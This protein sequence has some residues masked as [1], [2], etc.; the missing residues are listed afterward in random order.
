[1]GQ[2]LKP[3]RQLWAYVQSIPEPDRAIIGLGKRDSAFN[4]G[5]PEPAKHYRPGSDAPRDV[6]AYEGWEIFGLMDQP[7]ICAPSRATI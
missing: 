7:R 1:M 3:A 6:S 4:A 5:L 2:G